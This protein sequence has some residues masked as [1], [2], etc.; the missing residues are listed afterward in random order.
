VAN[1]TR[2]VYPGSVR[3]LALVACLACASPATAVKP[4]VPAPAPAPRPEDEARAALTRFASSLRG[5]RWPE[6]Y[7]LLSARWRARSSPDRLA[8]DFRESGPVGTRA[9]DRV[10]TLLALGAPIQVRGRSAVLLVGEGRQA[11]L[12]LEE[13]QWRVEALE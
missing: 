10:E 5:A 11:S 4:P 8:N 12:V 3:A 7:L 6:A 13:G 9:L 2:M 1:R